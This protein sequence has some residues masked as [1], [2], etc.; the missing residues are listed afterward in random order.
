[1]KLLVYIVVGVVVGIVL[2]AGV[3]ALI[4][5]RLPKTH[6]ASRSV[7]L[8]QSPMQVYA[9]V[10]DFESTPKWRSD[11][12]RVSV[13]PGPS[14]RL[15]L[16]EQGKNGIVA[17]AYINGIRLADDTCSDQGPAGTKSNII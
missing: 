11:V 13:Q 15:Q 3:I 6:T 14:G 12:E 9:V 2:L 4:G 5:S 8:H 1:M 17:R 16:R 7:L 10:R